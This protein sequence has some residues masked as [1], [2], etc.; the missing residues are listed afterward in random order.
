LDCGSN[1]A[2]RKPRLIQSAERLLA[3]AREQDAVRSANGFEDFELPGFDLEAL[4]GILNRDIADLDAQAAAQV[5]GHLASIGGGGEEWAEV[6]RVP[7][8]G[9]CP[10]CA[11]DL[12]GS[13]LVTHYRA[14][15]SA[16][17]VGLK[18]SIGYALGKIQT[19][20]GDPV[21]AAFE[22]AVRVWVER[23]HFWA[24]FCK[25]PEVA[26]DTAGVVRA[27]SAAR[28]TVRKRLL[29]KQA[30][31]LERF[32]ILAEDRA[33]TFE[34]ER[35][36]VGTLSAA[37]LGANDAIK[38][39]KEQ[40]ATANPTAI[41]ADLARL[42]AI[43][44]RHTPEIAA[45][46]DDYLVEKNAKAATEAQRNAVRDALITYR[47]TEFPSY[48]TA[49][50]EY[51]RK[52]GAGF[53]LENVAS[54]TTRGGL[55]CTYNVAI[56]NES[57]AVHSGTAVGTPSFRSTLSAG[58]RNTLALAFFFASLD[59]DPDL[60]NKVVVIDD[61]IMSLDEHRHLTTV[62]EIGRLTGRVGQLIVLSHTKAF[63]L[64]SVGSRGQDGTRG[65]RNRAERK[66]VD[67]SGLD[68]S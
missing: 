47:E 37:L 20:H 23:R 19:E 48:Q 7:P 24:Q 66:W 43:Q 49:I 60:G 28:D 8:S 36:R 11:Q 56:G 34:A 39:A 18:Q 45:L 14:Y 1:C 6:R 35:T 10:F 3:A 4:A 68:R 25:V 52:F 38:I 2:R 17:Y 32:E 5:Q 57:V 13:A 15:F 61:P 65:D 53:R 42:K 26:L 30:A 40:A 64:R 62:Q 12:G 55:A 22:G 51:L 58:D 67:P 16:Q 44:E 63:P 31:P 46:C 59:R 50:N 9:A 21:L 41:A 27:W 29:A 33:A 54:A